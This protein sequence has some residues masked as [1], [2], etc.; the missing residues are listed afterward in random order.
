MN[1]ERHVDKRETRWSISE[2]TTE[3]PTLIVCPKCACKGLVIPS[4]NERLKTVCSSCG[5]S[6]EQSEENHG[7]YWHDENPT[8]GYF[9]YNLWLQTNCAGHLLWAFNLRHLDILESFVSAKLRQRVKDE[10]WG[11]Q[12]SSLTSRL[13]NWIKDKKNRDAVIKSLR[14]LRE[15]A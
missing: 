7:F 14:I 13:P 8:D 9:G 3:D 15:K 6:T 1:G 5:F 12:N 10:K 4:K 2:P 11:W